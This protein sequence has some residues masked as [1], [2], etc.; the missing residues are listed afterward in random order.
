MLLA[1]LMKYSKINLGNHDVYAN[2]AGG[3]KIKDPASDLG[4]CL[5]AASALLEKSLGPKTLLLGEVGLSGE[6]RMV[7]QLER[8]LREAEKMGFSNAIIPYSKKIPTLA[9]LKL[10][11]V[12]NISEAINLIK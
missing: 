1:V 9:K 7:P 11:P 10:T 3:L 12:K 6:V 5:A 8:R 4:I 2:V